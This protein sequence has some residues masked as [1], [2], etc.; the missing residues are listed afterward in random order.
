MI[1]CNHPTGI[2]DGV[3]VWDALKAIRPDLMFYANADAHR[4]SPKLDEV[5]IP[6]EW[7]EEKRTRERTRL[8]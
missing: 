1:V 4:V 3:A 6:V 8:P 5:L 7:V 2:A